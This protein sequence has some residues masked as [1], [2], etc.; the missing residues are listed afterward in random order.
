MTN[1]PEVAWSILFDHILK[2]ADLFCPLPHFYIR[3]DVPKGFTR[4]LIE[5]SHHRV[6]HFSEFSRTKNQR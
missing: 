6:S 2:L 1:D 3:K 4:D 5:M